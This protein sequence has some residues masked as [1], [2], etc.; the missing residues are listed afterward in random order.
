M[1]LSQG[2]ESFEDLSRKFAGVLDCDFSQLMLVNDSEQNLYTYIR[3]DDGL[4]T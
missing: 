2:L 1:T 3:D 4:D